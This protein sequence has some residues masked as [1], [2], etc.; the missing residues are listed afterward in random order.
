MNL[1]NADLEVPIQT[2]NV[3]LMV[4]I[5]KKS[6]DNIQQNH[7]KTSSGEHECEI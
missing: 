2:A 1:C 3:N 5:V 7:D 4:A 6:G